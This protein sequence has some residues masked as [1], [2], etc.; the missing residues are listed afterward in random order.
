MSAGQIGN[1]FFSMNLFFEENGASM[2]DLPI[3][4]VSQ[5]SAWSETCTPAACWRSFCRAR[6]A[7]LLFVLTQTSRYQSCCR[8]DYHL[9]PYPALRVQ[10]PVSWYLLHALETVLGNTANTTQSRT[11][12]W[13]ES[14]RKD[15]E[16]WQ[17][18]KTFPLWG[19]SAFGCPLHPSLQ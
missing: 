7:L 10:W 2:A 11:Q 15:K 19:L 17:P 6:A 13:E 9:H 4:V 18:C 14:V 5:K 16:Q 1:S 3:G 12:N 8:V